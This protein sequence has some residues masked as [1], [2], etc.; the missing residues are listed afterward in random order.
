M[1]GFQSNLKFTNGSYKTLLMWNNSRKQLNNN[2]EV[3]KLRFKNLKNKFKHN[4]SLFKNYNAII[5]EQIKEGIVEVCPDV[6]SDSNCYYL[7]ICVN[8]DFFLIRVLVLFQ[9]K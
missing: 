9:F 1:N 6:I 7:H 4:G 2:F 8:H 5:Q 3:G